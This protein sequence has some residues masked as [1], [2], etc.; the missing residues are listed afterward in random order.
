MYAALHLYVVGNPEVDH[1]HI[2]FKV[3]KTKVI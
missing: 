2:W 1:G 3:N